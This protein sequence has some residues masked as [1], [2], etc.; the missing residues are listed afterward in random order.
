MLRL[1]F[2]DERARDDY[3]AITDQ[4]A[5]ELRIVSALRRA[6]YQVKHTPVWAR[7]IVRIDPTDRRR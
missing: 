7:H 1:G 3:R 2:D 6:G 5:R 4:Q